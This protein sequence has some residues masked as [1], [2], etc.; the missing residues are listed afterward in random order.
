M[1]PEAVATEPNCGEKSLAF[2]GKGDDI[3]PPKIEERSNWLR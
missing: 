3:N 1:T 2:D